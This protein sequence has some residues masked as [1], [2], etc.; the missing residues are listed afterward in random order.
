MD[1]AQTLEVLRAVGEETRLRILALLRRSEL[2]VT[3][4]VS[5][6]GQTQPRVSR[7]LKILVE[8][9]V[10]APYQEGA[11][12]FYRLAALPDWLIPIAEDLKGVTLEGDF[13]ALQQVRDERAA[14]ASAY[15][16]KNADS[17]DALRRLHVDSDAIE[18]AILALAPP[19]SAQYFDLGTG[20]GRMLTLLAE[21]Y[22]QATGYDVSPEMLAVARVKLE[23]EGLRRA[24]LRRGDILKANQIPG[25]A[26][27]LVSL[28][29]VLHFLAE[30]ERAIAAAA[31][32]MRP[33]AAL[34]IA[35]FAKHDVEE[36][37]EKHEHRK[38][39][40]STEEMD[41]MAARHGLKMSAER[42]LPPGAPGGLTSMV[43]RF[44][45]PAITHTVRGDACVA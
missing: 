32:A 8:A 28:H 20:T 24:Q 44:D 36:L 40:F 18:A 17:W 6:L 10:V 41:R 39:G 45:R 25:D 1:Y 12:R 4:L 22:E 21:R 26:A 27:D 31:T 38:L 43:W 33:G 3:E 2:T 13:S 15:F 19:R 29:H 34:L 7:H 16:A 30:P 42:V 11:W 9:G 35:D 37:R 14:R 23:E 5:C